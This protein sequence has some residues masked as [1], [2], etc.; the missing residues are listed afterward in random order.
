MTKPTEKLPL[1]FYIQR[2]HGPD[3]DVKADDDTADNAAALNELVTD[4]LK[5]TYQSL[6]TILTGF[7]SQP[8]SQTRR[9]YFANKYFF[10]THALPGHPDVFLTCRV[11][12]DKWLALVLEQAIKEPTFSGRAGLILGARGSGRTTLLRELRAH[13]T[14]GVD[15]TRSQHFFHALSSSLQQ[16]AGEIL[17]RLVFNQSDVTRVHEWFEETEK[18]VTIPEKSLRETTHWLN[19]LNLEIARERDVTQAIA[20]SQNDAFMR[21]FASLADTRLGA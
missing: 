12:E 4:E 18:V 17:P 1:Q 19:S 5:S 21:L 10:A 11:V 2:S 6:W 3:M 8:Q 15:I 9:E 16:H 20:L 13:P 14:I 7:A